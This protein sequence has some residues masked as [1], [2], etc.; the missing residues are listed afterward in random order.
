MKYH[1]IA[2]CSEMG[3]NVCPHDL[4]QHFEKGGGVDP[5]VIRIC[6]SSEQSKYSCIISRDTLPPNTQGLVV[7]GPKIWCQTQD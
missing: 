3:I 4:S 7:V 2:V 1:Y 5:H 6:V